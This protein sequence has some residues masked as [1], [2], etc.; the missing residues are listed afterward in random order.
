MVGIG[1]FRMRGKGSGAETET[2]IGTVI[3]F[4]NGKASRVETYLD[5]EAALEAAGLSE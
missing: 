1:R 4:K 2:P 3:D 5:P